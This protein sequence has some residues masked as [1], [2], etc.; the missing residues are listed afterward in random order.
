MFTADVV[1]PVYRPDEKL[2]KI[3]DRLH[4]QKMKPGKIILINTGRKYYE[5]FF[6]D[7]DPAKLYSD[8]CVTHITEDEFD[9]GAA[10]DMGIKMSQADAVICMTDDAL[11]VDANLIGEL[12]RPLA[13]GIAQS[14]YARQLPGKASSVYEAASRCFNYPAAPCVKSREDLVTMGIKT[15][16]CSDVCAAHLRKTYDELGGFDRNIIFNEDM[17]YARKLIDAG[18]HI[19]YVPSARVLHSHDYNAVQ[20]FK[21]SFDLGVSHAQYPDVFGDVSSESEGL[22]LIKRTVLFYIKKG[23]GIRIPQMLFYNACKYAGYRAGKAYKH[24]PASVLPVLS[25]NSR[26]FSHIQH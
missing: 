5:D 12:V 26:Y 21:R 8:V 24:L 3:I 15:F 9:H 23:E 18:Y 11:P 4:R 19:A 25:L 1:I 13:D 20:Y 6:G 14:S 2:I 7:E 22:K 10:R 16:F 17:I